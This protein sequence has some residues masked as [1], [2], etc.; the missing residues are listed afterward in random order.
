[1]LKVGFSLPDDP[2]HTI[3]CSGL[4]R[5][6]RTQGGLLVV[7]AEFHNLSVA[8]RRRI[9]EWILGRITPPPEAD[10][11]HWRGLAD[12]GVARAVDDD[13]RARPTIRWAPGMIT[14]FEE[15]AQHLDARETIFVPADAAAVRLGERLYLEVVPPQ[16]HM[17]FRL[18]AEVVWV[19]AP[20]APNPGLGLKLASLTSFDRAMLRTTL[21]FYRDEGERYR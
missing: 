7:G 13:E 3:S 16:G 14:L 17:L 8:D 11:T 2:D 9:S 21:K 1:M 15:V 19:Q 5:G 10:R 4:V 18:M 12:V 6:W 20:P